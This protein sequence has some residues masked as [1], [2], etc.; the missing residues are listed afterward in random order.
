MCVTS[1]QVGYAVG[2]PVGM[3]LAGRIAASTPT[4]TSA[5]AGAGA[6]VI[7]SRLKMFT[8]S[9]KIPLKAGFTAA[10]NAFSKHGN[11]AGSKFPK[12]IG[13]V[14]NK[15]KI[16]AELVQ[17]ILSNPNS[18]LTYRH[19]AMFGDIAEIYAPNGRGLRYRRSDL[20]FIGFIE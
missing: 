15:N 2:H 17:E 1:A 9:T 11:R 10:G 18:K 13:N 7:K 4:E 8:P 16:G 20:L 14:A 19:H 5:Y 6:L 3:Y 12:I